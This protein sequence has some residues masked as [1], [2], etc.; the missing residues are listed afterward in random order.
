MTYLLVD[1]KQKPKGA[2]ICYQI[3]KTIEQSLKHI[4]QIEQSNR[5]KQ[6]QQKKLQAKKDQRRNYITGELVSRYFPEVLK[7]EPGTNEQNAVTFSSLESFLSVLASN[8]ELIKQIKRDTT[9]N[10]QQL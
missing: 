7:L 10:K 4:A 5:I 3:K 9:N 1:P 8:Q 6:R 2:K